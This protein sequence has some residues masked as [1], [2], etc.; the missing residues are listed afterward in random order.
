MDQNL[1]HV[2]AAQL[3]RRSN[4]RRQPLEQGGT[5]YYTQNIDKESRKST[6][7]RRIKILGIIALTLLTLI[8]LW[9]IY[10]TFF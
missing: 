3:S 4:P 8:F 10:T 9:V 1:A 7:K 5:R 6:R 2:R